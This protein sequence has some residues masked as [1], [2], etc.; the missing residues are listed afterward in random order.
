MEQN[1]NPAA[2]QIGTLDHFVT[3]A[4]AVD[5]AAEVA[6]NTASEGAAS[7]E[8]GEAA[9]APSMPLLSPQEEAVKLVELVAWGVEKIFPVLGY[10]EETKAEAA[11]KL[12]PLMV[13]YNLS[14]ELLNKWG[15]E[16]EAGMF[17]GG[18]AYA[19]YLAV[20][21]SKQPPEEQPKKSWWRKFFAVSAS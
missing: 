19:S 13:K 12:A 9:Q 20:K 2:D 4:A 18:L 5:K 16:F 10:K 11:K 7:P 3:Q 17:F 21:A 14:S 6:P 8:G 1:Q 15:A